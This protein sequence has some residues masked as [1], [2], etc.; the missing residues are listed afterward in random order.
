M[1][2][3]SNARFVAEVLLGFSRS[4]ELS[5]FV[6]ETELLAVVEQVNVFASDLAGRI[7]DEWNNT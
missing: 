2:V 7:E 4:V 3:A 1:G 5:A 6:S